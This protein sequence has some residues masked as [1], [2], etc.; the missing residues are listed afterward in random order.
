M[1]YILLMLMSESEGRRE[2]NGIKL[3]WE[4]IKLIRFMII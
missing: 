1:E 3:V 4:S 2:R